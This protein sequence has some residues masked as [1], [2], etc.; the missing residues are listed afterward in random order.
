LD[1]QPK[2]RLT[3]RKLVHAAVQHLDGRCYVAS[4]AFIA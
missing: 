1:E 2:D 4:S 3:A